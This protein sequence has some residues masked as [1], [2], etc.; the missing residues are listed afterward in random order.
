MAKVA[1]GDNAI[2][3]H[4]KSTDGGMVSL[5]GLRDREAV[6][7]AFWCNHCPYVI[8]WEDRFIRLQRDYADKGVAFVAICANDAV[9]YPQDSFENMAKR[10]REKAYPFP[11]LYDETQEVASAYGAE[12]TPEIFLFD[13]DLRLAYHGAIDDDHKDP[14]A[15]R[16]HFLRDAIDAVLA[17]QAPPVQETQPIGCSVKWK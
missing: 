15:V 11:Y 12:R 2:Q 14:A 13:G 16:R 5:D 6:V 17:G 9:S 3:F 1:I 10:A 8:A 7:V 4:L